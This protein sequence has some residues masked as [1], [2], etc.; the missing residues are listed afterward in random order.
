M[1]RL[2]DMG[3]EDGP[4]LV[5]I[6]GAGEFLGFRQIGPEFFKGV[7]EHIR[8]M[9]PALFRHQLV[10]QLGAGPDDFPVQGMVPVQLHAALQIFD[11]FLGV[12]GQVL[13]DG[14][15]DGFQ[16]FHDSS[17][18]SLQFVFYYTALAPFLQL[19]YNSSIQFHTLP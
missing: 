12:P 10:Q 16:F 11:V 13:P 18:D 1:L 14:F 4:C 6:P 19:C 5:I 8:K 3:G 7:A 2:P 9:L 15:Q 17:S